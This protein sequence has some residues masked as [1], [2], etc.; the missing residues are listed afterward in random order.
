V[1]LARLEGDALRHRPA[2]QGAVTLEAKVVVESPGV[3][4]LDDEDGRSLPP[5]SSSRERLGS[6]VGVALPSVLAEA[7]AQDAFFLARGRARLRP[8]AVFSTDSRS[9]AIRSITSPSSA[10]SGSGSFCP[11]AFLRIRPSSSLRYVS[12]YFSGLKGSLRFSTSDFAIST[13]ALAS[14]DLPSSPSSD[15]GFFTSSG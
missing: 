10:S 1:L 11:F 7:I 12:S 4:A 15:A 9:A 2:R 8:R 14:F 5:R 3:M 6:L 13:S